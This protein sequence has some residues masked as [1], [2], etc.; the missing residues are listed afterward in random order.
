MTPQSHMYPHAALTNVGRVRD[1]NEDSIL[2]APPL[3]IVA[4]GLGGHEAGEIASHIAVEQVQANAPLTPDVNALMRAVKKANSA[5]IKAA[6]EH[7]GRQG[8][9]TTMTA[10]IIK[11]G[12]A[13]F[14]QV[15]DSRA[16]LL[17]SGRL[18]QVTEDHSV[19]ATMVRSGSISPAEARVHPQRNV[20]T[21]ALGSDPNLLVDTYEY[22]T[23][24]GDR[25]LL[26]SDGL[27]GPVNDAEI[28]EVLKKEID[29]SRCAEKLIELANDAGGN[30]NISAIIIDIDHDYATSLAQKK[31]TN[32]TLR[33]SIIAALVAI[34][35]IIGVVLVLKN[36]ASS[37]AYIAAT[38]DN[39]VAVYTG[40]PGSVLGFSISILSA[41]STFTVDMLP[42]LEQQNVSS[43]ET[44]DSLEAAMGQ[45]YR[46][47]ANLQAQK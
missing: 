20:I 27:F 41:E 22:E 36:Y 46:Y 13:V 25:W 43:E 6:Q 40:V 30:D 26:C 18:T 17:R 8:M 9:G 28:E 14:T 2:A 33:F 12:R 10:A 4:D 29:P 45:L 24:R 31:H 11:D 37:R 42:P 21:R 44:F 47:R 32:R 1:H 7:I 34:A 15:G 3:F 5:I 35:L 23:L 16:Y 38:P 19:V 39:H